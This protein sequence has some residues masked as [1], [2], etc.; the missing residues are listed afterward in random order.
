VP[1]KLLDHALKHARELQTER[2]NARART[3]RDKRLARAKR[4]MSS[5]PSEP[6]P[7][8]AE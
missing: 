4:E 5:V 1:H 2:E 8:A 7:G 3:K 6:L